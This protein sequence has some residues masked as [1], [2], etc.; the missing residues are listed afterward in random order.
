M[1]AFL[2]RLVNGGGYVEREYGVGRGRIDLLIRWPYPG[3]DGRRAWQREA[4]ELKVRADGDADPLA[5]GLDQLDAYLDRLGLDTGTLAIFDRRR[6]APP[7]HER[8]IIDTTT[9][10]AGRTITLLRG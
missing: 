9:S 2:Q 4:V 1:M 10:P 5:Q 3:P 6:T 8:T 7:I